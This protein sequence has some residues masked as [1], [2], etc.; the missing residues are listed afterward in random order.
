[1]ETKDIRRKNLKSLMESSDLSQASFAMRCDL[2]PSMISQLINGYRN[3]GNSL[4]RKIEEKLSIKRGWLDV[5]HDETI[6]SNELTES[7]PGS[8]ERDKKITPQEEHLVDLFRQ[9]PEREQSRII[10][11]LKEKADDYERIINEL[12][13]RRKRTLG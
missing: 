4:S 5:P 3:L 6:N 1:M 12:L 10:K 8:I 9:M 7:P 13:E 11:E 2:S